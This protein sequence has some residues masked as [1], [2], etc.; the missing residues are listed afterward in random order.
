[1]GIGNV[2]VQYPDVKKPDGSQDHPQIVASQGLLKQ[3]AGRGMFAF[4]SHRKLTKICKE[5][6]CYYLISGK[7]PRLNLTN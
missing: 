7:F 5:S 1:M 4:G 2:E 3:I 6:R